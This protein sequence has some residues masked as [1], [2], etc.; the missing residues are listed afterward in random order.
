MSNFVSVADLAGAVYQGRGGTL[1]GCYW[2]PE[3]N[4]GYRK[5]SS[6]HIPTALFCDPQTALAGVP[7]S[8]DGRNPLPD[9]DIVMHAFQRWGIRI[10]RPIVV[11]DEGRGLF[12]A[13]A[14]W[15]LRWAGLREVRILDGGLA[16]WFRQGHKVLGG[17]GNLAQSCT[18]RI[19]PG[20]MPVATMAD[21][22][23]AADDVILID[24]REPERF[25]GEREVLDLKAGHI[26][27]AINI[28]NRDVLR[29]DFTHRSPEEIRQRFAEAGIGPET[30]TQKMIIY[31]GSGNHSAQVIAA[32]EEAGLQIPQHFVG[33]WSQWCANRKSPVE[34]G[35]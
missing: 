3:E 2:R 25:A 15:I 18:V 8:A 30:P 10:D 19:N 33:G 9:P 4:A 29:E 35:Y 14:W 7:G 6:E 22:Q 31:S 21:V 12:A 23:E 13:R 20:Q 26:P 11:Y 5:F 24:T 32:M 27:G 34:R 28:P 16:E 17:P 1:L